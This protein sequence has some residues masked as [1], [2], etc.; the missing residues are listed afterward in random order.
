VGLVLDALLVGVQRGV[1][2]EKEVGREVLEGFL[3]GWGRAFYK[4]GDGR[5][6]RIRVGRGKGRVV[7]VLRREGVGVEVVPFRRGEVTWGVEWV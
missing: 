6:E 7:D 2:G 4:V 3:G 5:G 1:I